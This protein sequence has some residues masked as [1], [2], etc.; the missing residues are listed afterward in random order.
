MT[1]SILLTIPWDSKAADTPPRLEIPKVG[2]HR[3]SWKHAGTVGFPRGPWTVV[4]QRWSENDDGG[5]TEEAEVITLSSDEW[6]F[7]KLHGVSAKDADYDELAAL[8]VEDE[9]QGIVDVIKEMAKQH[10]DNMWFVRSWDVETAAA[11]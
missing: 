5:S 1:L 3:F 2:R 9:Y 10:P 8:I 6:M 11:D 4:P 7:N